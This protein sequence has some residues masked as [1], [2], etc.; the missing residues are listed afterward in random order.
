[1]RRS[2]MRNVRKLM[3][4]YLKAFE[5]IYCLFN[6]LEPIET[7]WIT[8]KIAAV[9]IATVN[10]YLFG[11]EGGYIAFDCGFSKA[12]ITKELAVLGIRP[13]QITHVFLTHSD[14]DHMGGIDLF[15]GAQVFLSKKEAPMVTG[16]ISRRFG[17]LYNK[18]LSRPYRCLSDGEVVR[19]GKVAVRAISTE[20]HTPGSMSYLVNGCYLFIGDAFRIINH[21]AIPIRAVFT[22]N[23][24][25]HLRSIKRLARIGG[26]K[27]VFTGHRGISEDYDGL[28]SDYR[29][30]SE[31]R[32]KQA[33]G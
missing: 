20:G 30:K 31:N 5:K 17:F 27:M 11:W 7:G 10:F 4:F 24:K 29:R 16:K 23:P 14:F 6:P 26:V 33:G 12:E 15:T 19:V 32:N 18:R 21:K 25:A 8:R 2:F 28:M 1:M 22:M 3:P 9:K 13:S